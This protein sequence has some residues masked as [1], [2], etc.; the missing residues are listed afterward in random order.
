MSVDETPTWQEMLWSPDVILE[1]WDGRV[2]AR[3]RIQWP[4]E[5]TITID[6]PPA[7]VPRDGT[8]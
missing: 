7:A 1:V 3:K 6:P 5:P 8:E 2:L 4:P